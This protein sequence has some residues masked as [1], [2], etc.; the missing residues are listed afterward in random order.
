MEQNQEPGNIPTLIWTINPPWR[1]EYA[2]GKRQS[3]TNAVIKT[4]QYMKN[5]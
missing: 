3:L 1:Q 5:T 4:G 2:M